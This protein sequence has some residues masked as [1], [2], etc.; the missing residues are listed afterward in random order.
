[1]LTGQEFKRKVKKNGGK[2][3]KQKVPILRLFVLNS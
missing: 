2:R 1:M 3:K